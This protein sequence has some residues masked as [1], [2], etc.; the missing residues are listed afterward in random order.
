MASSRGGSESWSTKARSKSADEPAAPP[1]APPAASPGLEP[2]GPL[3]DP[4]E[5][6]FGPPVIPSDLPAPAPP[7]RPRRERPVKPEPFDRTQ[8]F[9]QEEEPIY[10][11]PRRRAPPPGRRPRRVRQVRRVRSTLRHIDPLSVLKVSLMFYG[12]FLLL[13]LVFVAI[14]YWL[15][16]GAGVFQDIEAFLQKS[17][18]Q[19]SWS[20]SLSL[21]E[22]WAF[23]FGLAMSVFM[24][25]VNLFLAFLYN[26]VADTIGGIDMTFVERD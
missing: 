8:P 1:V 14:I 17:A 6:A 18:L 25:L 2:T 3:F 26:V 5:G 19:D 11:P 4:L 21:V 7:E 16:Q 20:L 12:V 9:E 15:V 10:A 22:K 23:F 13:W 24:S